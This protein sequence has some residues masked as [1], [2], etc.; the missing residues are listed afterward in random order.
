MTLD[1]Y[2]LGVY[3][4][5]CVMETGQ[6]DRGRKETFSLYLVFRAF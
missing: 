1:L 3:T 4:F 2:M 5:V 6:V